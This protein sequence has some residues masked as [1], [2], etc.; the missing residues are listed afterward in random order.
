MRGGGEEGRTGDDDLLGKLETLAAECGESAGTDV[1]TNVGGGGG[2]D[3]AEEVEERGECDALCATKDVED[4]G[5]WRLAD[6]V[7]DLRSSLEGVCSEERN[8]RTFMTIATVP[9][10]ECEPRSERK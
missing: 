2:E 1:K 4:L 7:G 9:R 6:G 5:H 8:E 10:R 3:V